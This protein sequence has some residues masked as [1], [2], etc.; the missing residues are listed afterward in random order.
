MSAIHGMEVRINASTDSILPFHPSVREYEVEVPTDCFALKFHLDYDPAYY[1]SIRTDHDAGRYLFEELDPAM[2]DYISGSEVPYYEY[3]DGYIVRLDKRRSCFDRDLRV[4]I[5]VTASSWEKGTEVYT[6][7]LL[8]RSTCPVRSLFRTAVF[9]DGG[10]QVKV[11]YALYVPSDYDPARRYPLVTALHGTGEREGPI[12]ALLDKTTMATAWA[13]DS[14]AGRNQC[15]VLVPQCLVHYNDEDNWTSLVQYINGHSN[16]PFWPLPQLKAVW[17]LIR[18]VAEEYSVDTRRLYLTGVSSGGFA[19][20]DMA[21]DLPG[22]FAGLVPVSCAANPRLIGALKGVPMWIFHS[23]SDPLIQ[24]SWAL[25]PCLAAMDGA[26]VKYRLTR[27]P[28]GQVFWQSGHFAWEV[29]Y[30]NQ[31]M[32]NWLFNQSLPQAADLRRPWQ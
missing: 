6:I 20:Y 14:E 16:S 29:C 17:N 30:H 22:V 27:Y 28:E 1:I 12:E 21:M 24:P 11:P 25:D 32:R 23:D 4:T 13:E 9:K 31:E 19:A 26:G 5:T 7:H 8:R 3:Y 18:K 15:L 2:G 10:Y